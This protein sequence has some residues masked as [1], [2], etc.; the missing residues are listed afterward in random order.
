MERGQECRM[1]QEQDI[2]IRRGVLS[3]EG[4]KQNKRLT[5]WECI[6]S[7]TF[8]AGFVTHFTHI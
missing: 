3:Q 4:T 6:A 7:R 1:S 5:I 2:V 8:R